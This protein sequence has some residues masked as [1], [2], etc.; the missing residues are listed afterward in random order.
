M[1]G[2]LIPVNTEEKHKEEVHVMTEAEIGQQPPESSKKQ[3]RILPREGSMTLSTPC[4][5][6]FS[7]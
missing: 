2:I 6:I 1:T 5:Q 4:F 3:A 7:F